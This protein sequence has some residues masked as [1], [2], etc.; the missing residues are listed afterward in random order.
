[1]MVSQQSEIR[2]ETADKAP[3]VPYRGVSRPQIVLVM[4][5][6][7]EKAAAALELG[8]L[9]VR[10]ANLIGKSEFPYTGGETR[11]PTTRAAT[12]SRST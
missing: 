5:R 12:A 3:A 6:L 8:P 9:Q 2:S 7:M 11:P 4:E 10:R 1:M